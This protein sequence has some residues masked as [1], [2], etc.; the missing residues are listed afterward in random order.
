M[1]KVIY[2]NHKAQQCGVY[3]FGKDIGH[4][5]ETSKKFKVTYVECDSF[6]ELKK[7][8]RTIKPDIILYNFHPAT[9]SWINWHDKYQ[10]YKTYYLDTLHIGMIH[11]VYQ[12]IADS[13]DNN[14][15]DFHIGPDPTLLLKNPLVYKTGRLL[16]D[17][18]KKVEITHDVPVVGSFG[19]ATANKGFENIIRLVQN[20]FDKAVV[21]LNIPYA[22][23]GDDN[24]ENARRI[25]QNCRDLITKKGIVLNV[26]H[27]YLERNELI[28][29]LSKN[30]INIFLYDN[31]A[32]RG[33]SSA[34]D[35]ALA[36]GR[37]LAISKSTLFRHLLDCNPSICIADNSLKTIINNGVTPI[38][39]F[40]SEYSREV[41]LWDYERILNSAIEKSKENNF[42]KKSLYKY[43]KE[44]IKKKLGFPV[45]QRSGYS[46]WAGAHDD[47]YYAGEMKRTAQYQSIETKHS[48]NRILDNSARELYQPAIDFFA[49]NLPDLIEKKIPEANVQQAFV[50]DTA[51]ELAKKIEKPK[52]LAVGA[53]EDTAAEGLKL[54]NYDIDFI[55]PILNYDIET[56]ITKP[57]V[58]AGAYDIIIST[59]V[60]EH[61]EKDEKFIQDIAYL[62][63][64]GGYGILTCDYNDQYKK[65]DNIPAVD[66]RFYTQH[67]LRERL[68]KSIPDCELVGVADWDCENPDFY[69]SGIYNYTFASLVFYKKAE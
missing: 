21:N 9:M 58:K 15:F 28:T 11:E 55:D 40:Y 48:L 35:W 47:H 56:F 65:G 27:S 44:R 26:D 22:K 2:V 63:K 4:L 62:L 67:D 7:Y 69:L 29:F 23:F 66:F 57:D 24:G 14:L 37:P 38:R 49:E 43:Y 68:M 20:E 36:S 42:P 19:F 30:T 5:L 31:V 52:I 12:E 64:K 46:S 41:V 8:Y 25:A 16:P 3:E 17:E 6:S 51:V 60:I 45:P 59:S 18:V 13:A 39:K 50:F 34:T 61:V 53:F 1:I 33:I 54:L 10:P 32:N